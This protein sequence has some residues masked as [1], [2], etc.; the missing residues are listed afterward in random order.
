MI[1][2]N[3]AVSQLWDYVENGLEAKSQ[4]EMEEHLAFCRRCCGE[5]EFAQELR[6]LMRAASKPHIPD[7]ISKQI[8]TYLDGLEGSSA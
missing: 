5:V 4:T 2:C 7:E 6:A 3:T 8:G 1:D